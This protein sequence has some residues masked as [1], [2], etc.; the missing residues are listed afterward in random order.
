MSLWD[1]PW[2]WIADSHICN[3]TIENKCE[4]GQVSYRA[5]LVGH[6]EVLFNGKEDFTHEALIHTLRLAGHI[7]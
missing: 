1:H 7:P 3:V 6:D 5:R 4:A 2:D